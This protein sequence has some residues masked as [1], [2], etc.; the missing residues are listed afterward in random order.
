MTKLWHL[1]FEPLRQTASESHPPTNVS[2][3]F[4]FDVYITHEYTRM[5]MIGRRLMPVNCHHEYPPLSKSS[6]TVLQRIILWR[7]TLL[8][9]PIDESG[10]LY[11]IG[12]AGWYVFI[13]SLL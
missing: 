10:G 5:T 1:S 13:T 11:V 12:D 2:I 6:V 9:P 3:M 8:P 4:S 7:L